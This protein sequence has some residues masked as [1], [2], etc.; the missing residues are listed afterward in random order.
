L[1]ASDDFT[2]SRVDGINSL[3]TSD[4]LIVNEETRLHYKKQKGW[5][6]VESSVKGPLTVKLVAFVGGSL[7][8]QV[9][10]GH[11]N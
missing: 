6:Q 4:E 2:I 5:F 10:A 11:D 7:E 9:S 1:Y 3:G 8:D